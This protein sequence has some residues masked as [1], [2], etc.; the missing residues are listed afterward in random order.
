[1]NQFEGP[2]ESYVW[3][4]KG[5]YFG[6]F[7]EKG[8]KEYTQQCKI[9]H[10]TS[11]CTLIKIQQEPIWKT[12]QGPCFGHKRVIFWPFLERG[13]QNTPRWE[14]WHGIS[15]D[16]LIKTQE[17]PIWRTMWG[18]YFGHKRAIFWPFLRKAATGF[19]KQCEIW[20]GT[21]LH[22]LRFMLVTYVSF[23]NLTHLQHW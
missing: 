15:M 21:F 11:L 7:W 22:S 10:G 9:W 6:H 14:I 17:E 5:P 8:A 1:M 12:M 16:T 3:T 13:L 4:I 2:C 18:P 23:S 20:H 19:T